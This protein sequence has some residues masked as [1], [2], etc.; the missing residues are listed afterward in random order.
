M[1]SYDIILITEIRFEKPKLLTDYI[2]NVLLEDEILTKALEKRGLRVGRFDWDR[3]DINWSESRFI[4]LRTPWNYHRKWDAFFSWFEKTQKESQFINPV[5]TV[6]WNLDKRYLFDLLKKG[7]NIAPTIILEKGSTKNLDQCFDELAC[8]ELVLK[9]VISAGGRDTYRISK[10]NSHEH[11]KRFKELIASEAMMVQEFQQNVPLEGEISLMFFGGK[12]SHA[13]LKKAKKGDFRVQDDFD[14]TVHDHIA[15]KEEMDF[16][17]HAIKQIDPI[18]V[19]ARVDIFRDNKGKL[20]LAELE[21][22]EP[23][24]WFRNDPAS[25]DLLAEEIVALML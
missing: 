20:A 2:S 25:A 24:L 4:L 1:A 5:S 14:G 19:Y 21:L 6:I 22:I 12:Y 13:V 15:T 18:P 17:L 8:E 23:E 16:A 9:P 7:V 3:Q 10:E 11:T